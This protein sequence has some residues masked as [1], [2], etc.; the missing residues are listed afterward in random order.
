MW[1]LKPS[2]AGS[3]GRPENRQH[4]AMD[5]YNLLNLKAD[6]DARLYLAFY[7]QGRHAE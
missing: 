1:R 4:G 5:Y 7:G 3:V 2:A 6:A